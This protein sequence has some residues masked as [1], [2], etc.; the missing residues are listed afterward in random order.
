MKKYLIIGL[1]ALVLVVPAGAKAET[2]NTG[3][4]I[5]A[6]REQITNLLQQ[7]DKM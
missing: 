1:L 7:I 3:D 5:T 2:A 4:S 6:L